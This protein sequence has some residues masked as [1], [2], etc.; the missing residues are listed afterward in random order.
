MTPKYGSVNNDDNDDKYGDEEWLQM[1]T[2]ERGRW[3]RCGGI[4]KES[5]GPGG[6]QG[7]GG[8]TPGEKSKGTN[9]ADGAA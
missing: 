9:R 1:E 3:R 5:I 6:S 2:R 8:G 7:L 4:V